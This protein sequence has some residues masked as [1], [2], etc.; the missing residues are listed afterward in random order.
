MVNL[1]NI[2]Q[3][4]GSSPAVTEIVSGKL[5]ASIGN[6]SKRY[7]VVGFSDRKTN[8]PSFI[9]SEGFGSASVASQNQS[10]LL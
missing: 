2:K 9:K 8:N 6:F 4:T 5:Q 10:I 3:V 1:K 7:E